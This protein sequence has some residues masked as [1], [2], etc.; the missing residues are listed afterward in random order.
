VLAAAATELGCPC[1]GAV[2]AL[3]GAVLRHRLSVRLTS[4]PLIAVRESDGVVEVYAPRSPAAGPVNESPEGRAS[5][6]LSRGHG[7]AA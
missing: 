3:D 7:A 5:N 2:F 4:L 6:P 1:H